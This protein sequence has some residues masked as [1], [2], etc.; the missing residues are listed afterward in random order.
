M[1]TYSSTEMFVTSSLPREPSVRQYCP[2]HH[3]RTYLCLYWGS[4]FLGA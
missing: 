3:A 2:V 4:M 1:V